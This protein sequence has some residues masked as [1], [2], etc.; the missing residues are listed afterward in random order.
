MKKAKLKKLAVFGGYS[1][2]VVNW[3]ITGGD[4]GEGD[5]MPLVLTVAT[6]SGDTVE[7]SLDYGDSGWETTVRASPGSTIEL[8][9]G[10]DLGI[11]EDD[12]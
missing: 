12:P 8:T 1:D 5:G 10:G 3:D 7:L 4:K 2:D 6:A 11:D 9:S